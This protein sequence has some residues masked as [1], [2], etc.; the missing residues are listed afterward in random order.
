MNPKKKAPSAT[1]AE[2]LDTY[3]N[4]RNFA[5]VQRPG[6]ALYSVCRSKITPKPNGPVRK[7]TSGQAVAAPTDKRGFVMPK[8][9]AGA[10]ALVHMV[11][12]HGEAYPQGWPHGLSRVLNHHAHPLRVRTHRVVLSLDKEQP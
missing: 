4:S 2:G 9:R 8:F 3:Q 12:G 11:Y 10:P 5:S 6:K 1:N 7:N